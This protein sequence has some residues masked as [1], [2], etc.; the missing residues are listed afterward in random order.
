MN[1]VK[2]PNMITSNKTNI[3]KDKDATEQNLRLL[4]LSFKYSMFGDPYFGS[5]LRKLLF[6]SNNVI[7]Q[8][9]VVDDI[10]SVISGYMPQIKVVRN[11]I[12]VVSD[13][14]TVSVNIVAQN[15]L[16]YSYSEYSI[17]LLNVEEL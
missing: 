10:Y 8:S 4:L 11:N 3:V 5:N 17:R 13:G 15:M 7:L 14:N 12:S 16:D 6:E 1:A 9:L 2:F